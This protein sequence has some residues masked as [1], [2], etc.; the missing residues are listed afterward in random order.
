VE[1]FYDE[2]ADD[3]LV[4][5]ADGGLNAQT[6]EEFVESIEKLVDAGLTKLIIDCERLEHVSSYGLGVLIR[7]HKGVKSHGGDV[8]ICS[9]RGIVPQIL[10]ATRLNRLFEI[11]PDVNRAR[12]AFWPDEEMDED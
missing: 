8:K 3:V 11:Y 9:L 10:T 12:L 7:L 5:A 1:F 4:L 6:A 2:I